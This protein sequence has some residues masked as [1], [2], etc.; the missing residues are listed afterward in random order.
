M[1]LNYLHLDKTTRDCMLQELENDRKDE[2]IYLSPRLNQQD[3]LQWE[4]LLREAFQ[5]H[6]DAWLANEITS[7]SLLKNR[8]F[9]T[10]NGHIQ[11]R[12]VPSNAAEMLAEG[13]FNRYYI[14]ALCLRAIKDGIPHLIAYRAR[15]SSIPRAATEEKIDQ[16]YNP[17]QVLQDLR[18]SIGVE[19]ALGIPPGP[20]SGLSLRLP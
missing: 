19:P 8:E 12:S 3:V 4:P 11:E 18:T 5:N 2:K 20:N 1:A 15:A 10:R 7:Q 9:Y 17:T 16:P 14:R 13:E 6:D